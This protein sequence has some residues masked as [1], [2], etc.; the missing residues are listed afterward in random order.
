MNMKRPVRNSMR[1]GLSLLELVIAT[2]MLALVM[3]TV[4]VVMRTG[5]QAWEAHTADYER[6][7]AGHAT[8]RHLVR[9][10][11][12]ARGVDAVT[13]PTDASGQLALRLPDGTVEVWDHDD[14]TSNVNYGVT[15][16]DQ[17]LAN[18]IAG[19]RFTSYAANGTTTTMVPDE[20]RALHLEV[21]V[22]LPIESGGTRLIKS[23]AWIR[24]W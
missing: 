19:L 9:R 21:T 15:T 23:W 13:A 3:T 22:Q 8:L 18:N 2:S 24:S 6:I 11:R 5:R 14:A 20:I 7:E 12:Q 1:R 10:I 4:S 17:L 16:P